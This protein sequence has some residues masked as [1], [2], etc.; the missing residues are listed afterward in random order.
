[1]DYL[2][3]IETAAGVTAAAPQVTPVVV[4]KGRITGGWIHFPSGPAGKL[5]LIARIGGHQIL[6]INAGE[7]YRLDNAVVPFDLSNEILDR[8][9]TVDLITWNES[10]S[11]TH[12]LTVCLF[13]EQPG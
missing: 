4:T 3:Y 2:K 9:C 10:T 13:I 5:H 8:P 6:P 1:M 11:Y 7:S 12:A